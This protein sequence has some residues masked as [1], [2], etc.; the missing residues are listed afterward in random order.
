MGWGPPGVVLDHIVGRGVGGSLPHGLRNHEE[1]VPLGQGHH[2]VKNR[3]RR[4]V[5][6]LA[7]GRVQFVETG[8]DPL[9]DD[10]K[11]ELDVHD[12]GVEEF[13]DDV[14]LLRTDLFDLAFADTISVEDNSLRGSAIIFDVTAKV[15]KRMFRIGSL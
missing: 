12:Q 8:I 5:D 10:E 15:L 7:V 14:D 13:A 4:R 9:C 2:V 3:P 6:N 11:R 1:V